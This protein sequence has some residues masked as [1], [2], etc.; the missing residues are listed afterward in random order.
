MSTN[1]LLEQDGVQFE[2]DY[3]YR[4]N[5]SITST[6]DIALTEFVANA[7]DAGAMNVTITIPEEGED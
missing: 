4:T 1:Y 5:R 6:P 7:W 2:E 3:I